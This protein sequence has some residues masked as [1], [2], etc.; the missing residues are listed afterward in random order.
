MRVCS[1]TYQSTSAIATRYT[2]TSGIP[3]ALPRARFDHESGNSATSCRFPETSSTTAKS[4]WLMPRVAMNELTFSRTTTKP[5]TNPNSVH[6]ATAITA[7]RA[8][9]TEECNCSHTPSTTDV[10]ITAPTD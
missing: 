4:T 8:G 7:P 5:D 6:A 1:S 9:G 3:A 2:S 10:D